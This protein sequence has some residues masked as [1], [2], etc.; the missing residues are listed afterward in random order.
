MFRVIVTDQGDLSEIAKTFDTYEEAEDYAKAIVRRSLERG[1]D[2][3]NSAE[4]LF[5]QFMGFGDCP[6]IEGGGNKQ[7]FSARDYARQVCEELFQHRQ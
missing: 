1:S 7:G 2:L 4:E 6:S 3:C 5:L